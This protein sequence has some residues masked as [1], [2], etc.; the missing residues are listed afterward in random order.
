MTEVKFDYNH[1]QT[2][3]QCNLND[4]IEDVFKKYEIKTGKDISQLYFFYIME[5]Q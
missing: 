4:K 5:I 2:I 3:I 1:I